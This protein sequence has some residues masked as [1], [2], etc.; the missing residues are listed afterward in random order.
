M[1]STAITVA[2]VALLCAGCGSSGGTPPSTPFSTAGDPQCQITYRVS[3]DT[4][5]LTVFSTV[6]GELSYNVV[7][8]ATGAAD[9]TRIEVGSKKVRQTIT[10]FRRVTG[11]VTA[12]AGNTVYRCSVAPAAN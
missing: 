12:A 6:A 5:D 4:V 10:G 11:T 9:A 3:G 7:G 8:A 2:T 1:R